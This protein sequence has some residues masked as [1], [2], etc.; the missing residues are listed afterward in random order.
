MKAT[1]PTIPPALEG[2]AKAAA[3][4]A[5]SHG[6]KRFEMSVHLD[7]GEENEL[8]PKVSNDGEIKVIYNARDGRGRPAVNLAIHYESKVRIALVTTPESY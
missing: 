5:Q 1:P 3:A 2:F 8:N 4:L 7:Y 6:I